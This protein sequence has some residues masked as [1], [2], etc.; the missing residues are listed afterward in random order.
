MLEIYYISVVLAIVLTSS[1]I[2]LDYRAGLKPELLPAIP[3][4]IA[5]FMPIIN[6]FTIVV[7]LVYI[8]GG[9]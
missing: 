2:I 1:A 6:I 5:C 3:V 7:A 8:F 4:L 9:L